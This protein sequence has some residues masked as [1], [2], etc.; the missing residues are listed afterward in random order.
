MDD[1]LQLS[2]VLP[3]L[4]ILYVHGNEDDAYLDT[5]LKDDFMK[6]LS[7]LH[8]LQWLHISNC[9]VDCVLPRGCRLSLTVFEE[10]TGEN[11]H[12]IAQ[13]LETIYIRFDTMPN[14]GFLSSCVRLSQINVECKLY[15]PQHP[16]QLQGLERL[17]LSVKMVNVFI[18]GQFDSDDI[19]ETDLFEASV[20]DILNCLSLG[21]N[22]QK[23]ITE[24]TQGYNLKRTLVIT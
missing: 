19:D 1:L 21:W 15:S 11:F 13:H 7:S 10:Y 12:N 8:K 20:P 3:N 6:E 9:W 2:E 4:E 24:F 23:F 5:S 14:L 22:K 16:G 18:W 17:P